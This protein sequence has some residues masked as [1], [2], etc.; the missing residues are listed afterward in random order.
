MNDKTTQVRH[1]QI[2]VQLLFTD[3]TT[4]HAYS[5]GFASMSVFAS[6]TID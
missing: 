6:L 1:L 4:K 5:A 3:A 2:A